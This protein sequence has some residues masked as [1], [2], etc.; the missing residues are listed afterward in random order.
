MNDAL[1]GDLLAWSMMLLL[2]GFALAGPLRRD[3]GVAQAYFFTVFLHVLAAVVYIYIPGVLPLRGDA[4]VFHNTAV[5]MQDTAE[6]PFGLS[7]ALYKWCM[8]HI[9]SWVGPSWLFVSVLSIYAFA[10]SVI[11]LARIMEL[12]NIQHG[13]GL[14]ILF[15][16]ALPTAVLYGSVPMREPYQVLFFMATCHAMIHFRLTGNVAYLLLT[17]I[18]ALF[19]ALLHKG[20]LVYAPFLVVLMLLVRVDAGVKRPSFFGGRDWLHRLMAV[21][22]AIGFVAALPMVA[23][24]LQGIRGTNVLSAVTG[25]G[26]ANFTA[27]YRTGDHLARARSSYGVSLDTSSVVGFVYSMTAIFFFYLFTPFPWQVQNFLDIYAF[28]EVVIRV[29]TLFAIYKMWR[30]K[31]QVHPHLIKVL[32]LVYL[33]MAVLWAAGTTNYGTAT[34]HHMVHQW[35]ILLLGVP[36]LVQMMPGSQ[37]QRSPVGTARAPSSSSPAK[38]RLPHPHLRRLDG[39]SQV[40]P[41]RLEVM[42]IQPRGL[43]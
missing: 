36:A 1:T 37:S 32:M 10:L 24:Q 31:D 23:D 7:S 42:S 9:Y 21:S 20:L 38:P 43:K 39:F 14:V 26:L 40:T 19:M 5:A 35:I 22:L 34:R 16:G 11:I 6:W 15:F 33:T 12:L 17:I 29:A 8:A 28:G 18:T 41:R 30:S 25:D 27:K 4:T 13:K 3:S 2:P